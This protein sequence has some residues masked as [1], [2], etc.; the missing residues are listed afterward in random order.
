[1][2]HGCG[3][4]CAAEPRLGGPCAS[5]RPW[6]LSALGREP[7][8]CWW[9]GAGEQ[10]PAVS[11]PC[12]PSHCLPATLASISAVTTSWHGV[13]LDQSL[14]SAVLVSPINHS[15]IRAPPPPPP[16]SLRAALV[17]GNASS[18]TTSPS[19][20]IGMGCPT[21]WAVCPGSPGRAEGTNR[22]QL[23]RKVAPGMGTL[24]HFAPSLG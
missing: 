16:T 20:G 14:T 5:A 15:V 2:R 9:P 10:S 12:S 19:R 22:A 21:M 17:S 13:A 18:V 8:G 3:V 6:A 11:R 24:R 4:L 7:G 1:M 23:G